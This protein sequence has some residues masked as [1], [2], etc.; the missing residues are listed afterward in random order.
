MPAAV[1]SRVPQWVALSCIH[2]GGTMEVPVIVE[3]DEHDRATGTIWWFCSINCRI[4]AS[5]RVPMPWITGVSDNS[6]SNNVCE[7]CG[8]LLELSKG[9]A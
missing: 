6:S 4:A 8:K 5:G 1:P 3:L 9:G 7:H 2:G